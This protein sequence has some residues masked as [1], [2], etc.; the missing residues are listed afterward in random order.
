M[1]DEP[2]GDE[3]EVEEPRDTYR[4]ARKRRRKAD[5]GRIMRITQ[6]MPPCAFRASLPSAAPA[7]SLPLQA[8][9]A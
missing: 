2:N 4:H 5:G 9:R 8:H 6:G 7:R 1:L 3:E